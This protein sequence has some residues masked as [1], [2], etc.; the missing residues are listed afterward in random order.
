MTY[1]EHI[2]EI[3]KRT[4][5]ALVKEVDFEFDFTNPEFAKNVLN[6]C[7]EEANI[8][9][10]KFKINL[11]FGIRFYD[12]INASASIENGNT[13]LINHK[14]INELENVINKNIKLYF[15][16]QFTKISNI[17]LNEDDLFQM[18]TKLCTTYLFYHELAHIFQL[19]KAKNPSQF[20][21]TEQYEYNSVFN[22]KNHIY[23][24]DADLFGITFSTAFFLGYPFQTKYLNNPVI[25]FHLLTLYIGIIGSLFITFSNKKHKEIYFKENS[26]PHQIIR[27]YSCIEQIMFTFSNY[28]KYSSD[29]GPKSPYSKTIILKA[30]SLLDFQHNITSLNYSEIAEKNIREIDAYTE[31]IEI[32]NNNYHELTRHNG[33]EIYNI[34]SKL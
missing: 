9:R 18:Y 11:C 20:S 14:L 3:R 32:L 17:P 12:K 30:Y 29:L 1:S 23:E 26:H 21:F 15:Q 16:D 7:I 24:L 2:E 5:V 27:I 19:N 4:N 25:Q 34:L 8:V 13:I 10:E 33:R 6:I 22:I 28:V 31:E